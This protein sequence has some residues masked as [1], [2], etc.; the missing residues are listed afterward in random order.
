MELFRCDSKDGKVTNVDLFVYN[1]F[2]I[3]VWS[4]SVIENAEA[5]VASYGG[6]QRWVSLLRMRL[7]YNYCVFPSIRIFF[8]RFLLERM[9]LVRVLKIHYNF[10][11]EKYMLLDSK[12]YL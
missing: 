12:C 3:C 5:L 2:Y 4:F 11:P 8:G 9:P 6:L 7:L 10:P 1:F